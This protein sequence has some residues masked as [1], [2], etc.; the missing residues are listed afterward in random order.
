[1]RT[2]SL[3]YERALRNRQR[4]PDLLLSQRTHRKSF[5]NLQYVFR[6]RHL[7]FKTNYIQQFQKEMNV[8]P[9]HAD[10]TP[11]VAN[12][13]EHHAASVSPSTKAI[14][15]KSHVGFLK[16]RA[17]HHHAVPTPNAHSYPTVSR[18]ARVCLGTWRV[19]IPSED[20]WNEEIL[21]IRPPAV[22][23]PFAIRIDHL[24][25]IV[26]NPLSGIRLKLAVSL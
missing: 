16:T 5:Q 13:M 22:L 20:V 14:H 25:V 7:S 3:W 12:T 8:L 19:R 23:E 1:M 10:R 18:N 11:D 21:V 4:K 15:P 26:L 24:F 17:T 2:Q 6:F 9:T